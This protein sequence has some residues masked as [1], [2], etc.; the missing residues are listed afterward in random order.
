MKIIKK[1]KVYSITL[2]IVMLLVFMV[3][4]ISGYFST[5]VNYYIS[6]KVKV[7][8]SMLLEQ[9]IREAVI[10]NINT[11][12][13]INFTFGEYNKIE[14]VM[15]NTKEVN[16]IMSGVLKVLQ[17]N[18]KKIEQE[19]EL[20]SL[21]LPLGIILSDTLFQK[22][23][24]DINILVQP[25]GSYKVDIITTAEPFGINNSLLQVLL[26]AKIDFISI[27][28]FNKQTIRTDLHIPLAIEMVSGQVPRY[29][30]Y[31]H[32]S[33]VGPTIPEVE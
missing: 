25:V 27:I 28:P 17:E 22:L 6:Q 8:S 26:V 29:Y 3:S 16:V 5:R 19:E 18:L 11:D 12:S 30:Y 4:F 21:S 24:P 23:G 20:N 1:F 33:D 10:P 14:G 15:I 13:L 2:I 7:N 31:L 9:A 32:N